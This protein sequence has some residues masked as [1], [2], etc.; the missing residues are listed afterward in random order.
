VR[1]TLGK[2][3]ERCGKLAIKERE[4][5]YK[6]LDRGIDWRCRIECL[7]FVSTNTR[8]LGCMESN[9]DKL[10]ADRMKKRGL[11]W[12]IAGAK[13]MG[14]AIQLSMNG[15][16]RDY[17]GRTS[18]KYR[19]VEDRLSFDLFFHA[20]EYEHSVSIPSLYGSHSTLPYVRVLRD[21]TK[22]DYPII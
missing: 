2:L 15:D 11:S 19:I 20:P 3:E 7:P 22:N 18:Y 5:V 9:E 6:C 16:L 10:F 17:C 12:T 14:K 4:H 13:R 1:R 21:L 8:G